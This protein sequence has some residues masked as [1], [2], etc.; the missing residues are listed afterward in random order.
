MDEQLHHPCWTHCIVETEF[1]MLSVDIP[2]VEAISTDLLCSA[3]PVREGVGGGVP[4]LI[5]DAEPT[6]VNLSFFRIS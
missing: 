5:F 4:F 3:E 2:D 1:G 6:Q